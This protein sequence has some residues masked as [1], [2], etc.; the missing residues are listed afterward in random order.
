VPAS[1]TVPA[2]ATTAS[3]P[4]TTYTVVSSTPVTLT[5]TYN[6]GTPQTATLTVLP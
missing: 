2:G 4:V 1:V 5:A 3:F 6:G